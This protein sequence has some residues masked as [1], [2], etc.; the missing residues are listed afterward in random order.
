MRLLLF[1]CSQCFSWNRP[2]HFICTWVCLFIYAGRSL[3]G[4]LRGRC[5]LGTDGGGGRGWG[6][7][8]L[9]MQRERSKGCSWI[10][11]LRIEEACRQWMP[12]W[13][14]LLPPTPRAHSPVHEGLHVRISCRMLRILMNETADYAYACVKRL[15]NIF[16][17]FNP[18]WSGIPDEFPSDKYRIRNWKKFSNI[19]S[20]MRCNRVVRA[21]DSQCRSHNCPGFDH[22]A[23]DPVELQLQ[24][25]GR[26]W[27]SV[28]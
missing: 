2:D 19:L 25:Q 6:D 11:A 16:S 27:S 18:V 26:R 24:L 17:G 22:R 10:T 9:H 8:R 1:I 13:M 15:L 28:E 12:E 7:P 4:V 23:P 14:D 20:W 3:P 21:S 5:V